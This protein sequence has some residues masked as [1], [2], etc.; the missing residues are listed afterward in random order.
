MA[1][2]FLVFLT[3][4]FFLLQ[5]LPGD[6]VA[7]RFA[8]NPNIPPEARQIALERLGLDQPL[9][10]Q[11][12]NY[13][14][15]FF[16]GDLGVS[17]SQYP[18]P[19]TDIILERLPRTLLLFTTALI[20]QYYVGFLAGKFL[21]WRRGKRGELL[22]TI[23]GVTLYTV[24]YPWFA[25]MM[26]WLFAVILDWF[27][28][29][30]FLTPTLWRDAPFRANT[31][32]LTIYATAALLSIFL[33]LVVYLSRRRTDERQ[34]RAIRIGGAVIGIGVFLAFW[35][36]G[37]TGSEMSVYARDMAWHLV[38]P[39]LTL[40]LIGFAGVMLLTRSS[41]LDTMREDYIL[42]ARAKGIPERQVRDRHAARTAL[43]PV[44]TSLVLAVAAVIDG[45]IV[46]ETVFS[47]PGMGQLLVASVLNED[48]PL[49]LAAFAFV[50]VL[51]LV[52]HLVA[53]LLYGVLDP[54]IR[55]TAQG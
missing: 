8:G 34:R 6:I 55:V 14:T 23:G 18:R 24:F 10:R 32:F 15:N 25:L 30:Q 28:I 42:T 17:F 22:V 2:L 31:V 49:A 13:M 39:V 52:G 1:L 46:T 41:M 33:F 51:A 3:L 40:T 19:V 16:R 53:D 35:T 7:Q 21:A 5:A 11:Y 45:G 38:L 36:V 50:G 12:T 29:G 20:T 48:I 27:P 44:T 37:E 47:W 9:W 4:T 54:R 26:I 43:L